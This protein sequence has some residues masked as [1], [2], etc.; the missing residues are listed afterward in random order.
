MLCD[1][2]DCLSCHAC[3]ASCPKDAISMHE[4]EL[5]KYV[6]VIDPDACVH[7]G[8]CEKACPQLQILSRRKPMQCFAGYTTDETDR[9][10]CASGGF[11][12]AIER[13]AFNKNGIV[14]GAVFAQKQF[15]FSAFT[16]AASL[17]ALRG[18]KYVFS[19]PEK[20][21]S[22]VRKDL[23]DGIPCVFIG[24]PC[25]VA[26]LRAFL[27]KEYDGLATVD[28]ICHGA[29]PFKY[30]EEHIAELGFSA[31]YDTVTFR[32]E[33]N[34]YFTVKDAEGRV[35]Y[36]KKQ[37]ED[38]YFEAFM[39]GLI[40]RDCC[41]SCPFAAEE[42]VSDITIGDF[43]GL[44]KDALKRYTGRISCA[45]LNTEKGKALFRE[46]AE[47]LILEE[48]TVS[49]AVAGNAQLRFPS[50]LHPARKQFE[51]AYQ[52]NGFSYAMKASGMLK[53]VKQYRARNIILLVPRKMKRI[54]RNV[55]GK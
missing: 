51:E 29:P 33:K 35:L 37:Q 25:Q 12:A 52:S 22:A 41:Y 9:I 46:A 28:L 24:L 47:G 15:R 38:V 54:V 50:R 1:K 39:S 55:L 31:A 40:H 13:A 3:Y 48:R 10:R 32:G 2:K 7:C 4:D 21:Y 23:N 18:S 8:L 16:D 27:G 49:E 19:S 45:L 11:A 43:W 5:G 6:P 34:F 53:R 44:G 20:T 30:L 14:Y 17:E 36:S 26:G 42:R